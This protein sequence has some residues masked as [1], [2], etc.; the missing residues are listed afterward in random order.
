MNAIDILEF[1]WKKVCQRKAV[2]S[3]WRK[4]M[5]MDFVVIPL[6]HIMVGNYAAKIMDILCFD[7]DFD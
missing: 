2:C 4:R 6:C 7:E 3:R 1:F 5:K